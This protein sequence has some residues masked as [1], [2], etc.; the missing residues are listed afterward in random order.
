MTKRNTHG[1]SWVVL[2]PSHWRAEAW[3]SIEMRY[4]GA[5]WWLSDGRATHQFAT[6]DGTANALRAA[7]DIAATNF[8]AN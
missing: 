7:V 8:K 5:R 1:I 6:R 3:P 2:S 4:D